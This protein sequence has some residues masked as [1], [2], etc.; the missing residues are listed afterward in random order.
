MVTHMPSVRTLSTI[1]S[2]RTVAVVS[3]DPHQQVLE[4]MLDAVDPDV[5]FVESIAHAYSQIKSLA[6]DLVILC[7]SSD[8]RDGWLVLSMLGL[9]SE[10]S[11]IPV[12]T[13]L[14]VPTH[15]RS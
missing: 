4:A 9:D 13:H 14:T 15:G 3:R 8:D 1:R 10:T 5:V 2:L 7:L 12:L 11:R 6:P